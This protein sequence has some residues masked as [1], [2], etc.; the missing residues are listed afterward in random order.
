[1]PRRNNR[2][3][4][5]GFLESLGTTLSSWGNS[6]SQGATS[7]WDKTKNS[8]SSLTS[9]APS[10]APAYSAPMPAA[11]PAPSSFGGRKRSRKMRGG[12]SPNSSTS[13]LAASAASFSGSTAQPKTWVGGKTKKYKNKKHRHSKTCRHRK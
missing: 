13:G 2:K 3:M 4:S 1:M 6:V 5:G 7:L 11:S 12:F 9:S 8:A 10:A